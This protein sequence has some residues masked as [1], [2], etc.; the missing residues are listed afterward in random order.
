MCSNHFENGKPTFGNPVPTL[1]LVISDKRVSPKKR[2]VPSYRVDSGTAAETSSSGTKKRVEEEP[3]VKD[4]AVQCSFSVRSA[5]TFA[6]LT[7]EHDV[8]FYTGLKNSEVFKMLFDHLG[9]KAADMHYWK[10][11][12]IT[13]KTITTPRDKRNIS[14]RCLSLEQEF[15]LT[16]MR[17]RLGLLV[18]DLA[19]RFKISEGLTSSIFTT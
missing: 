15:L 4:F 1:Y 14:L 2:K 19:F 10:G 5:L 8:M 17:L 12:K 9:V 18:D 6:Q 13:A 3:A 11:Q 7:R 16:M